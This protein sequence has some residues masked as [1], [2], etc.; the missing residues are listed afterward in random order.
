VVRIPGYTDPEV[1]LT[2]SQKMAFFIVTAVK[3]SNLTRRPLMK[4]ALFKG[5]KRMSPSPHL[6][7]EADPVSETLCFLVFRITD[8]GQNPDPQ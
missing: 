7:T 8:G 5:L 4:L 1:P 3:T 2:T 6:K